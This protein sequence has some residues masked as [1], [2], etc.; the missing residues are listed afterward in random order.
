MKL[1]FKR[2]D[3]VMEYFVSDDDEATLSLLIPGVNEKLIQK[4]RRRDKNQAKISATIGKFLQEKRSARL[5]I[6]NKV[7]VYLF[8]SQVLQAY[9]PLPKGPSNQSFQLVK[10]DLHDRF[11]PSFDKD[12]YCVTHFSRSGQGNSLALSEIVKK[13]DVDEITI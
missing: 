7:D 10:N 3:L 4:F 5:R 6:T 11:G 12:Y 9:L 8:G 1:F 2:S 13:N